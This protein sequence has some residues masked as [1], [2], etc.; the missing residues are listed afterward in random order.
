M[1]NMFRIFASGL[2]TSDN[3]NIFTTPNEPGY[4]ARIS[5]AKAFAAIID[6]YRLR[7][8]DE[9]KFNGDAS[10]LYDDGEYP[11]HW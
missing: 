5:E 10:G 6:S 9:Y 8:D 3:H 7:K 4:L 1:E 2:A 11:V